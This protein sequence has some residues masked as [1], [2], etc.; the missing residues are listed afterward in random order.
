MNDKEQIIKVVGLP[1]GAGFNWSVGVLM[2][3]FI[4]TL[5]DKKLLGTR[6]PKCGYVT[7]PPRTICVKCNSKTGEDNLVE[8][9][10]KG[11]L[12]GRTSARVKLDGKCKFVD[13]EEPEI[14]GAVKLED[15][16]STLFMPIVG[17]GAEKL[18]IGAEVAIE[19]S[20][21]T[22]GEIS[23]IKGFKPV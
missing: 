4:K 10:G 6:C 19:W 13:L 9:S 7:T 2:E 22:K 3:K 12:A 21:E 16:N 1:L 23:D 15:A 11:A 18:E 20:D 8:L 14:I 5:A 17:E